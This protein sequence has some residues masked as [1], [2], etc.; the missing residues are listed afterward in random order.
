MTKKTSKDSDNSVSSE[1][2][3]KFSWGLSRQQK[4]IFG[5]ALLFFSIALLLSFISYFVTGFNDQNI[6]SEL[7]NRNAKAEN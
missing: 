2:K 5:I 4:F 7:S 6:V 3:K 1:T